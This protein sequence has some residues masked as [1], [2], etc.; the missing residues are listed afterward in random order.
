M[1]INQITHAQIDSH[2]NL[3]DSWEIADDAIVNNLK[4]HRQ[5]QQDSEFCSLSII[6]DVE[7]KKL[8]L[9]FQIEESAIESDSIV[10]IFGNG[11]NK[12][13]VELK[14]DLISAELK[15]ATLL[16]EAIFG[17][18]NE[19]I[20]LISLLSDKGFLHLFFKDDIGTKHFISVSLDN[21]KMQFEKLYQY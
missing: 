13:R 20:N 10:L 9:I 21:F 16:D 4:F 18:S 12:T 2:P 3:R 7:T 8:K 5:S 1:L 19:Q 11:E 17:P 14:L 6:K 15:Q